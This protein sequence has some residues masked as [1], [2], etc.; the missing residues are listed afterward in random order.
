MRSHWVLSS[1]AIGLCAVLLAPGLFLQGW[2]QYEQRQYRKS[3]RRVLTQAVDRAQLSRIAV[4]LQS[5]S[6]L[7]W[8]HHKEF[9]YRGSMYDVVHRE[10][11]ADSAIYWCWWDAEEN[12]LMSDLDRLVSGLRKHDPRPMQTNQR[13]SH[14]LKGF[15]KTP[16]PSEVARP[17]PH[18]PWP[19]SKA[20]AL[21]DGFSLGFGPPPRAIG[22]HRI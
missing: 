16:D 3:V 10:Y 17:V 21:Q 9:R 7:D 20:Y 19:P 11:G 6:E 4:P 2:V 15:W 13:W 1:A 12:R 8:V 18:I 22:P 14:F 5:A